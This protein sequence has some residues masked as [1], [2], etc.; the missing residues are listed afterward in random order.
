MLN[1]IIVYGAVLP[2]VLAGVA[3]VV[4]WR[5]RVSPRSATWGGA[6]GFAAAFAATQ[7]GL[8][9]RVSLPPSEAWQWTVWLV[10]AAMAVG[11]VQSV[12]ECPA[13]LTWG[14]RLVVTL[15]AALLA[16]PLFHEHVTEARLA[17]AAA[18][19]LLWTVLD[20]LGER[21]R[22]ATLPLAL[23][24][25][26]IAAA[27]V[28]ERSANA[29]LAQLAGAIAAA[30][31]AALLVG[32][33]RPQLSL[34]RGAAGVFAVAIPALLVNGQATTETVPVFA[35]VLAGLAPVGVAL[36]AAADLRRLSLWRQTA[37]GLIGVVVLAGI[38][39]GAAFQAT[40][41]DAM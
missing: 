40:V 24:V 7:F 34:A 5:R 36:A 23:L 39:V 11:I 10:F 1:D 27:V 2:V 38:A 13:W 20:W 35:F 16:V 28:L 3:L 26:A 30:C 6:V 33:W 22:G 4:A 15:F 32:I 25:T 21:L 12:V 17:T 19:L 14:L 18:V 31:G 29:K 9:G 8:V 37:T 41:G